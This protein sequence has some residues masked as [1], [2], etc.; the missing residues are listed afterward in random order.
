MSFFRNAVWFC[1]GLGEYTQ[2]GY[3]AA[4]KYFRSE[5]LEVNCQ[6]KSYMI[7]GANSGIGKQVRSIDLLLDYMVF[8]FEFFGLLGCSRDC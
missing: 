3:L 6:G 5:D 7:T 4:A 1:K 8:N 2:G